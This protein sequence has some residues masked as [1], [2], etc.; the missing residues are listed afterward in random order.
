MMEIHWDWRRWLDQ[1]IPDEVTFKT[2]FTDNA[3]SPEGLDLIK[4]CR[5]KAIPVSVCPFLQAIPDLA[6]YLAKVET[7]GLDA[8]TVYEAATL[9]VAVPE[10]FK[11][12]NPATN[13]LLQKNF[14]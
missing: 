10:G 7:L 14:K 11:E 9:W 6:G 8:F 12:S 3:F 2:I 5:D 13:I 4:R 1:G